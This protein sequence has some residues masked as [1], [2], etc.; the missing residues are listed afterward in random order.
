MTLEIKVLRGPD[1]ITPAIQDIA[2]LR[3]R[4]FREWPYIYDGSQENEAEYLGHFAKSE[5]ACVGLAID[6]GEVIGATT[7]EPMPDTHEDFRK[8]FTEAG[9]P[10]DKIFY[11]GESVLLS[12]HR[13]R[14]IG[15]AFF[16]LRE[17][18]AKDWGATLTAFCAVQR[19]DDH[20]LKPDT[21]RPLDN[22]WR[23]RGYQSR[24]DLICHFPWKDL[25]EAEERYKPLMFWTR[26]LS[27]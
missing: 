6:D 5:D 15:H 10:T 19:P 8:P 21:Y 23:S 3:I 4:V 9:I 13:G 18:A 26:K 12:E 7:A 22:F 11:F 17:Q 16:D 2:R 27:Q 20:P 14:G 25:N 24:E 1:E